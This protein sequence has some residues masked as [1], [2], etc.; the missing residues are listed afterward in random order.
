MAGWVITPMYMMASTAAASQILIVAALL[1]ARVAP[2][3]DG[4]P[5]RLRAIPPRSMASNRGDESQ[6][7]DN[8]DAARP[9]M[10]RPKMLG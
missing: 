1:A 4:G 8:E 10:R 5:D 7:G 9:L 2:L 3:R 6:G